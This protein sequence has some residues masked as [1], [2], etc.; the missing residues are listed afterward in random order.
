MRALNVI[1]PK[2]ARVTIHCHG[3]GC[4]FRRLE[5]SVRGLV[6]IRR[7]RRRL[8]KPHALIEVRVTDQ[9]GNTGPPADY[10]WTITGPPRPERVLW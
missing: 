3:H 1:A 10:P 8:L 9:A 2:G 6:R 4:A 7:L 5:R